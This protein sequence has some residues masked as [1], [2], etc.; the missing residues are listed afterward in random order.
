MKLPPV[1]EIPGE[2]D[3]KEGKVQIH[4]KTFK[5][6]IFTLMISLAI[7]MAY[8]VIFVF[9]HSVPVKSHRIMRSN[10]SGPKPENGFNSGLEV[11][12]NGTT[13]NVSRATQNITNENVEKIKPMVDDLEEVEVTV[14]EELSSENQRAPATKLDEKSD[15]PTPTELS[16]RIREGLVRWLKKFII[17]DLSQVKLEGESVTIPDEW[18]TFPS[19][20]YCSPLQMGGCVDSIGVVADHVIHNFARTTLADLLPSLRE[21]LIKN[22]VKADPCKQSYLNVTVKRDGGSRNFL[23]NSGLVQKIPGEKHL[24]TFDTRDEH[25]DSESDTVWFPLRDSIVEVVI[26]PSN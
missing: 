4:V 20:P 22:N 26:K 14:S 19:L 16:R 24:V 3:E 12:E 10:T 2:W 25:E 11:T 23:A 6:I 7:N 15:V 8:T 13:Q 1:S 9:P 5:A 18:Q 17:P 21:L